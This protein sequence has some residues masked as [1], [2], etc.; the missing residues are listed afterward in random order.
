[1]RTCDVG[2]AGVAPNVDNA[3][4]MGD[5]ANYAGRVLCGIMRVK[6]S[7]YRSDQESGK[8]DQSEYATRTHLLHRAYIHFQIICT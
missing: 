7:S 4:A 8:T 5:V 3:C 6:G 1:M 2:L